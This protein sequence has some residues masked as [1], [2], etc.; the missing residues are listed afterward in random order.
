[1]TESLKMTKLCCVF[2]LTLHA[3]AQDVKPAVYRVDENV[4]RGKQPTKAEIPEL[5]T[6]GIKTVLDLRGGLGHQQ[7]ERQAVEAAGMKYVRVGLSG[8]FGPTQQQI[9]SILAVLENPGLGP[10][11]VHCRRGAD[12]SGLVVACYRIDHDHWTNAQAMQ[13]A[14]EQ[15]FSRLEVLMRRYIEHFAPK[16]APAA[17][18]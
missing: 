13:E 5:A 12:R 10:I 2:L 7:W 16:K 11:F 14:R 8:L 3:S 4:F 6:R 9:D 18:R 15:G 17:G 1:M